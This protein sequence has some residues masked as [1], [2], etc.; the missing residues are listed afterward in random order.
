MEIPDFNLSNVRALQVT[1]VDDS[2]GVINVRLSEMVVGNLN[3]R[4]VDRKTSEVR[5]EGATRPEVILRQL[6]T[7]PGQVRHSSC[8]DDPTLHN[9]QPCQVLQ[10]VMYLTCGPRLWALFHFCI[11][12][13]VLRPAGDKAWHVR[14]AMLSAG[15]QC[16]A[17]QNRHRCSVQHG[18][19]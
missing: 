13:G 10:V 14:L 16:A 2:S 8:V 9:C 19:L 3:L 7:R 11:L 15:V 18:A 4:Y 5:E 12:T 17:S 6:A 1:D